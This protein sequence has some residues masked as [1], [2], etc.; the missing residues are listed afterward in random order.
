MD[1][2]RILILIFAIFIIV[3]TP[4]YFIFEGYR[5][6]SDEV[7]G[8]LVVLILIVFGY[9]ITPLL[10]IGI[11]IASLLYGLGVI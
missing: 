4:C 2:E 9:I 8:I 6:F 1:V 10:I 3:H 7:P 11:I 5:E